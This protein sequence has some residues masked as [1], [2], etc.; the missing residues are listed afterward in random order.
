MGSEDQHNTGQSTT[1]DNSEESTRERNPPDSLKK[2][3]QFCEFLIQKRLSMSNSE[4]FE[5]PCKFGICY[6]VLSLCVKK[7][8][9][10]ASICPSDA[11]VY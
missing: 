2:I 3:A 8:K 10:L 1:I 5:R 11:Q 4:S 7:T 9:T 6:T